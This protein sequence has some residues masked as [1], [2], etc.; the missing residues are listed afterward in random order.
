MSG[1]CLPFTINAADVRQYTEAIASCRHPDKGR[2]IFA[3]R[4][5]AKGEVIAVV[6]RTR[7]GGCHSLLGRSHHP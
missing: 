7:A 2:I 4:E 5:I 1:L 3:R 6:P